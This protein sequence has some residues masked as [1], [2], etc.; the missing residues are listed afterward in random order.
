VKKLKSKI[1]L[2][3]SLVSIVAMAVIFVFSS[4]AHAKL[5]INLKDVG[6]GGAT[7]VTIIDNLAGDLDAREGY[8]LSNGA[9]GNFSIMVNIGMTKPIIG[10][11]SVP[12]MDLNEVSLTS[13]GAGSVEITMS[14]DGFGP[15][16][17]LTGFVSGIGGTSGGTVNYDVFYDDGVIQQIAD[18]GPFGPGAFSGT[19]HYSGIPG[20]NPY[21]LILVATVTH[22]AAGQLT[23]FDGDVNM[24]PEPGTIFLLG[25]GL[26]GLGIISKRKLEIKD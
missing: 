14:E 13:S 19:E 11:A 4:S 25:L 24:T 8:I 7:P 5:M 23:T 21:S 26:L 3:L 10:S 6:G 12:R 15:T 18:M 1:K 16:P 22:T 17:G 9:F 20:N 2:Y